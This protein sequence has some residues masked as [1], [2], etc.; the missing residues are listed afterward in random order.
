EWSWGGLLADLDND[1]FKD[2]FVTNGIKGATN[3][4]D[5]MNFIDNEDIQRRIDRGMQD[6]D[7]PLTREIPAKKVSNYVFRNNGDL[8]F[9]DRT[10]LWIGQEP[11]FSNGSAYADLDSDGDLDLVVN[12]LNQ[13]ASIYQNNL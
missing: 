11:S 10:S 9:S 3:D 5:Y 2:L 8:T 13:P 4:M 12:N 1:G 7:L 6:T